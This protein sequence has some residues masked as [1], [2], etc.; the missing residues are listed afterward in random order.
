MRFRDLRSCKNL[1]WHPYAFMNSTTMYGHLDINIHL[2][3]LVHTWWLWICKWLCK[4]CGCLSNQLS[5]QGARMVQKRSKKTYSKGTNVSKR[6][7]FYHLKWWGFGSRRLLFHPLFELI[8]AKKK[9]WHNSGTYE[10]HEVHFYT[11]WM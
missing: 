11:I 10:V 2:C 1:D 8:I 9:G 5:W 6:S 7:L 4:W 3:N